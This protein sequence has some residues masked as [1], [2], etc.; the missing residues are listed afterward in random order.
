MAN[1]ATDDAQ[2]DALMQQI[3]DHIR[4]GGTI[5]DLRGFDE[6]DYE[7]MYAVG[8][9]LYGQGRYAD[10]AKVFGF[11][12]VNNPYDRRFPQAMGATQQMLGRHDDAAGFYSMAIVLDMS[13]PVP[14]FHMAECMAALGHRQD[15][16]EAFD[17]VVKL[18]TQPQQQALRDKAAAQ[19][20]LLAQS[21]AAN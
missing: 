2:L 10:A 1:A 5:G 21:G 13:D 12:V 19:A 7:V 6:K 15:A 18:C 16:R 8:H 20:S 9:N 3:G 17:S 4:A 11:L 14:L